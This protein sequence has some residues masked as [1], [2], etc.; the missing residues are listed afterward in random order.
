MNISSIYDT[1]LFEIT[2]QRQ[3]LADSSSNFRCAPLDFRDVLADVVVLFFRFLSN[4]VYSKIL[5]YTTDSYS[6]HR[7]EN[8]IIQH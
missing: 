7:Y 5:S 2:N 8:N 4:N 1:Q 3:R 6:N